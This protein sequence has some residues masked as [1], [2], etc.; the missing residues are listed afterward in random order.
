MFWVF[1]F[2]LCDVCSDVCYLRV[3]PTSA[4]PSAAVIVL[5][6]TCVSFTRRLGRW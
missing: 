2:V 1:S 3:L 4:T 5:A 6:V